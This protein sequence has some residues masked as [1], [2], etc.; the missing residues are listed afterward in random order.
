MPG[1]AALC[2]DLLPYAF[3]GY[4]APKLGEAG[5]PVLASILGSFFRP[6]AQP[7]RTHSSVAICFSTLRGHIVVWN[8]NS[9]TVVFKLLL[10]NFLAK[11]LYLSFHICKMEMIGVMTLDV[12]LKIQGVN[13]R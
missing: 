6:L 3:L 13:S 11:R 5:L 10:H 7:N 2:S 1:W 12:L 9:H 4:T 8:M